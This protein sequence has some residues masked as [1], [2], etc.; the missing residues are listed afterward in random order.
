MEQ[1]WGAVVFVVLYAP[2]P[3]AQSQGL[4]LNPLCCHCRGQC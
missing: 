4:G 3:M 1:G 2:Y